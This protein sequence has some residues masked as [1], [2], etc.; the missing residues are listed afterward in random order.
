[1]NFHLTPELEIF[2]AQVRYFVQTELVP[3]ELEVEQA[4]GEISIV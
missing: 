1:M 3:L 4:N 2:R